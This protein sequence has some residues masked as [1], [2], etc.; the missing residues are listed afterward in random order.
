MV[1]MPRGLTM[2]PAEL[3]LRPHVSPYWPAGAPPVARPREQ[4]R[5][6][7]GDTLRLEAGLVRR[8]LNGQTYTMYGFNGQYPGPLI[9][10]ARG[11]EIVVA[12]TN[13]LP[14]STTVH[15]HGIRLDNRFDGV[16]GLTQPAVAPGGAFMY[17][18]R[19]P[20]GGIY[21]YHPHVR[22][23]VQQ[24][25]GLYGNVLVRP[26]RRANAPARFR[27]GRAPAGHPH[28]RVGGTPDGAEYGPANREQ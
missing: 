9:E 21:W 23:D 24:E 27:R 20:D 10:V 8:S 3:A 16:S 28:A 25:L 19:F 14:E 7:D 5:L 2:L 1:P 6:A 26:P 4:R 13:H 12:F 11:S 22:E 15:W 18:V 17:R